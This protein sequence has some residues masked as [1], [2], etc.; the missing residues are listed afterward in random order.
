MSYKK[1][2]FYKYVIPNLTLFILVGFL[3]T[4]SVNV[5][6]DS[7]SGSP[8]FP[9]EQNENGLFPE[10]IIDYFEEN[11]SDYYYFLR[12]WGHNASF[13]EDYI[14]F[15]M[16]PKENDFMFYG[17]LNNNGYQFSIYNVGNNIGGLSNGY[18][19]FRNG[20]QSDYW[21]GGQ[22]ISGWQYLNSSVYDSG[23]DFI[24]NFRLYSNSNPDSQVV[25]LKYGPDSPSYDVATQGHAVPPDPF[26]NPAVN[27]GSNHQ[28]PREVPEAPTINNYTWIT[29]APPSVD[30]SNVE[31]LLESI[32]DILSYNAGYLKNNISNEF[33]NLISNIGDFV[34]YI[35]E[36]IQYYGGLII[37]NIQNGI[38]TLYEN[39]VALLEP[40]T[41][42]FITLI[43][44]GTDP[45]TGM[46]SIPYLTGVMFLPDFTDVFA[47]LVENDAFD[48][49]FTTVQV[50]TKVPALI[51]QL[52]EV[53]PSPTFHVP[54]LTYH[55]KQIGDFDI[56]FSWY[57]PYKVYSDVILNAFLILG[58]L[59]WLFITFGSHLRGHF[60]EAY[61]N[62]PDN[63]A[64]LFRG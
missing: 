14:Y 55:G 3:L 5:H 35:A 60:M 18:M 30:N 29:Y 41:V 34:D 15:L 11:Y 53:T 43:A 24:S 58:Y 20:S 27:S 52:I 63:N 44:M 23:T 42:G 48:V 13:N 37:S 39:F 50:Y 10:Y 25:V 19:G 56:S 12:W 31:S 36:T 47:V 28:L 59:Y 57:A 21:N 40:I 17:E 1:S 64:R 9:M 26:D 7:S 45:E 49:L 46:F 4:F 61:P 6:A 38:N 32:F 22:N 2:H 51:N 62:D 54:S 8:Y 33:D 16:I